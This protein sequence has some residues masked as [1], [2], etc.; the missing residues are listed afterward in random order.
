M[1]AKEAHV[2]TVNLLKDKHGLA[3]VGEL[4]GELSAVPLLHQHSCLQGLVRRGHHSDGDGTR[5]RVI[6]G[7]DV[8]V[9]PVFQESPQLGGGHTYGTERGEEGG[10]GGR[11]REGGREG[12]REGG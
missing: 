2:H 12:E 1:H 7:L 11:E 6:G 10:E 9:D 8:V 5:F 4:L 3:A